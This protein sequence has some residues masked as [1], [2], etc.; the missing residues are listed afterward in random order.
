MGQWLWDSGHTNWVYFNGLAASEI[1]CHT[2]PTH[3]NQQSFRIIHHR[4]HLMKHHH[5]HHHLS[6][7]SF[8]II[9]IYH[10]HHHPASSSTSIESKSKNNAKWLRYTSSVPPTT[11]PGLLRSHPNVL[12]W[13]LKQSHQVNHAWDMLQQWSRWYALK[14]WAK[15]MPNDGQWG[16]W[17]EKETSSKWYLYPK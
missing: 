6:S 7:S 1:S 15:G 16:W 9:I 8:I 5:H 12:F 10:H 17:M 14:W 11:P 3:I 13:I 4:H 2:E